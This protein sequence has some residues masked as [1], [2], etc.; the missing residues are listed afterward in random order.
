MRRFMLTMLTMLGIVFLGMSSAQ[1]NTFD[2]TDLSP[3]YMEGITEISAQ[4][5]DGAPV[6]LSVWSFPYCV[7]EDG[8]GRVEDCVWVSSQQGNRI[9]QISVVYVGAQMIYV[10][11]YAAEI[12]V[13]PGATVAPVDEYWQNEAGWTAP[14]QKFWSD[15]TTGTDGVNLPPCQ[16]EGQNGCYWDAQSMGNGI[17]QDYVSDAYG[18]VTYQ[19]V[20]P[21]GPTG[22]TESYVTSQSFEPITGDVVTACSQTVVRSCYHTGMMQYVQSDGRMRHLQG[23]ELGMTVVP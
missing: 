3:A 11:N 1:A 20:A 4:S 15:S 16:Y 5:T 14:V 13:A 21:D 7:H 22:L 18:N 9:S 12:L 8:A 17:G 23:S 19:D 10:S 6:V 2:G